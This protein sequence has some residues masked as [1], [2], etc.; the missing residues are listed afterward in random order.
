MYTPVPLATIHSVMH[1]LKI[2]Q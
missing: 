1:P 2:W